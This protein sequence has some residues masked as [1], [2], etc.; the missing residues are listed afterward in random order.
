MSFR[1][2]PTNSLVGKTTTVRNVE[3]QLINLCQQQSE[4]GG[5]TE[6]N[7]AINAA[8]R[9]LQP[10]AVKPDLKSIKKGFSIRVN[11]R[12]DEDFY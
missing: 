4:Y 2:R 5:T 11:K 8:V 1:I 7:D 3:Q 6:S 12:A 9:Y 10:N